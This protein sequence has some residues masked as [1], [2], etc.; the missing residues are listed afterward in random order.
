MPFC[1]GVQGHPEMMSKNDPFVRK[2]NE[3]LLEYVERM[4]N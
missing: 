1:F 2:L 4:C 3:M